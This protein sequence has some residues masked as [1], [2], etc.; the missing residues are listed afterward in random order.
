MTAETKIK[1]EALAR[2]R[3]AN[4]GKAVAITVALQ[5]PGM[6][7]ILLNGL[8]AYLLG[9]NALPANLQAAR[10]FL[11][12]NLERVIIWVIGLLVLALLMWV[13]SA[14]LRLGA[15]RWYYKSSLGEEASVKELFAFY[16][17]KGWKRALGLE[18]SLFLR[19]FGWWLLFLLPG[20]ICISLLAIP[21]QAPGTIAILTVGACVCVPGA[22]VA[23]VW[24]A[25]G[26]FAARTAVVKWEEAGVNECI[27]VSM[28]AMKGRK[29]S[30][31][32]LMLSF[33]GWAL[34][35]FFVLPILFVHPY[36][37]MSRTTCAKWLLTT[38]EAE[39]DTAE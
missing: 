5:I 13:A 19:L 35:T 20:T 30:A 29:A 25:L 4:W 11:I 22:M 26:Y 10:F 31:F 17:A 2:L 37:E 6:A 12:N 21:G 36:F 14:P 8:L 38:E 34:L 32:V 23:I 16:N 27:R 28:H 1:Q 33:L 7:L 18:I 3:A 39:T 9:M 24:K 15:A